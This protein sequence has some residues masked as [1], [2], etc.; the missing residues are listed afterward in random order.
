MGNLYG[1]LAASLRE[2]TESDWRSRAR[3]S[4][5]PPPGDWAIWLLL[6]GRGFGKTRVLSEW[7]L[8]Q[9][10]AGSRRIAMVAATASDCRDV[11][12]E[13]DS[14]ILSCAPKWNRPEYEPTKRRLTWS[15]GAIATA[16]SA[17]ESERL[18]GPQFDAAICDE[19]GAW[20][21]AESWD[22]LMLGLRLGTNPRC[23]VATTPKPTRLIRDLVAREGKDVAVTRGRTKENEANLAPQFLKTI[24]ARFQGTRLGRQELDGELLLDTPNALWSHENL[25]DTRVESAPPMQRIVVG[26]DP[27]GSSAE[28]ADECG[29]VVSGLGVDSELYV[30]A[31]LSARM[32]PTEWARRAVDAYHYYKAD[33]IVAETNYGGAMVL[34]TIAA[35]DPSVPTKAITSSRGKVLR[36][37]PISAIFEQRR[38]HLVGSNFAELQDQLTSFTSD[39]DRSRGSPDRVDAMV[40]GMSEL[41]SGAA[42]GSYFNGAALLIDGEPDVPPLCTQEVFGV[43]AITP[44]TGSAVGFVIVATSPNDVPPR[45]YVL[46]WRIV[47][48]DEALSVEWLTGVYAR[49]QELSQEWQSLSQPPRI[50]IEMDDFGQAAFELCMMHA[51]ETGI[52]INLCEID[53]RRGAP[54]PTLE[55][56]VEACRAK[57]NS[58]TVKIARLAFER[59]EPFRSSNVNHFL[60]QVLTFRPEAREAPVELVA[61][62]CTGV[63]LWM[64]T[65]AQVRNVH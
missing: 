33:R 44:L 26:V 57:I 59:Q 24:V 10:L 23:V 50:M 61:A 35:I 11:L 5:L 45:F 64:A 63:G 16:Y 53:R 31:D 30:L 19:L 6:A 34:S 36:A 21:Y 65:E 3:P 54:I 62:L 20:R 52:A 43:L 25:D 38:G 58:G 51:Y 7:V 46:D 56:R 22:M 28:D 4:Q 17:D 42:P 32:S 13:G 60:T 39:W 2:A 18:R 37:E 41:T 55:Q 14:G 40:F 9:V 8:E 49:V 1:D 47:E 12:I 27:S 29:I 15:N 48:I